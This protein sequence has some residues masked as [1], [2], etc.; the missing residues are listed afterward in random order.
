LGSVG[1]N[2]TPFSVFPSIAHAFFDDHHDRFD[3][4]SKKGPYPPRAMGFVA[5]ATSISEVVLETEVGFLV[6]LARVADDVRFARIV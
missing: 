5:R 6:R 3:P 1:G 2:P 4:G